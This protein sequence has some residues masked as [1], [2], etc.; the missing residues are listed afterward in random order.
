MKLKGN[1]G[2]SLKNI[3]I[4][5]AVLFALL[6]AIR[7]YQ[8][9]F[10]TDTQT[11]FFSE[12]NFT[13]PLM[14]IIAIGTVVLVSSLCYVSNDLPMGD[15]KKRPSPLY[16]I[17]GALF[18]VS[19]LYDGLKGIKAMLQAGSDFALMKEAAGGNLG[20]VS[21]VFGVLGAGAILMSLFV[22]MQT[23]TLTGKLR[24]PMLFPVIWAF[25]RTLAFFSV[26][27]SY[28]KVSQLF[29]SIFAAAF[30]MIFLFENARVVTGTGRND[31]V[32]FYFASGIIAAGLCFSAGLPALVASVASPEKLVSYAPF[33]IYT[34]GG[35]LYA[36]ASLF[37]RDKE[38][39]EE[40]TEIVT[41]IE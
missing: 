25:S 32:W 12:S 17:A 2:F 22:L 10:L 34:I 7:F 4:G 6:I 15:I 14:F 31:A 30:L 3:K 37:V 27:V 38:K 19:L 28:L 29:L 13:V 5:S 24:I 18:S 26:T 8:S 40:N 23:G 16:F 33:E 36:L 39:A 9:F 1:T 35:G 21:A 11:G 41:E 20:I